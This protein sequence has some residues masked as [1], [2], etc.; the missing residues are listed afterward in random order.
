MR[1]RSLSPKLVAAVADHMARGQSLCGEALPSSA[2]SLKQKSRKV[3]AYKALLVADAGCWPRLGQLWTP[4]VNVSAP[5]GLAG[6]GWCWHCSPMS[7]LHC[8][9]EEMAPPNTEKKPL[10]QANKNSKK[11][12]C[13][14]L[15]E[16]TKSKRVASWHSLSL[17]PSYSS[18]AEST[19][20]LMLANHLHLNQTFFII[21]Q[22]FCIK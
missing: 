6:H 12:R 16:V 1:W 22:P 10:E 11:V 5:A 18:L 17:R 21:Q 4:G 7:L 13:L 9:E 20:S 15:K 14:L 19:E 2:F 8:K 3:G